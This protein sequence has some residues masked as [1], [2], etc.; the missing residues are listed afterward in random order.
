[1]NT[2]GASTRRNG[3]DVEPTTPRSRNR[4]ICAPTGTTECPFSYAMNF[5]GKQI[6]LVQQI[7]D[8]QALIMSRPL[9]HY[10]TGCLYAGKDL[11]DGRTCERCGATLASAFVAYVHSICKRPH[12][13]CVCCNTGHNT[14]QNFQDH[15]IT[16][17][18]TKN[19]AG[20][21]FMEY[22]QYQQQMAAMHMATA[23]PAYASQ[24]GYFQQPGMPGVGVV[25]TAMPQQAYP[26]FPAPTMAYYPTDLP[27]MTHSAHERDV[28]NILV[29][30]ASYAA[31]PSEGQTGAGGF[32]GAGYGDTQ[33]SP[34]SPDATMN[35]SQDDVPA[36]QVPEPPSH[37]Q[38]TVPDQSLSKA[39]PDFINSYDSY[40]GA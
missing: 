18:H 1:M 35:D 19:M 29:N 40:R 24:P 5:D 15:C 20:W 4:T 23:S 21:Q 2:R 38:T 11:V 30:A 16:S 7:A 37:S 36:P 3:D 22:E 34:A 27:P 8:R 25:P 39:F 28:A 17:K 14:V 32:T 33:F 26:Y 13:K 12:L 10:Q 9:S 6:R 31:A